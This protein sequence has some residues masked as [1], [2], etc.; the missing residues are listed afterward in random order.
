[1]ESDR[2]LVIEMW[3]DLGCPWC[4][5]GKYRLQ[6]AIAARPD[7]DRFVV[8]LHSF[9]LNPH[10]PRT[11]ETI[12][13][14]FLRSHGGDAHVVMQAERRVQAIARSE[15]LPFSLDRLN[16]NTFDFHRVT[17]YAD[18]AGRGL[19]F[20]SRVQDRFFAGVID[21]FD[22]EAL[23]QV[24]EETGLSAERVHAVLAS[25]SYAEAVRADG[26]EGR[27]LGAQG[28]PFTVFDRRFAASGA[29]SVAVYAQ[30]LDRTAAASTAGIA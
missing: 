5:I 6:R 26:R 27:E 20:F 29:Q 21:P 3:A 17:H 7:A 8:R 4:Y 12:E 25:D 2:P 16:A 30:A 10:A 18:E 15:G 9:E 28:V 19:E 22:P 1:V 14:A 11:P 23:A 13:S 24:A